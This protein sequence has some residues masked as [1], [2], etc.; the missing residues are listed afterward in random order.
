MLKSIKGNNKDTFF[1]ASETNIESDTLKQSKQTSMLRQAW[2]E[3]KWKCEQSERGWWLERK[4]R[5]REQ[6]RLSAEEEKGYIRRGRLAG[7]LL[8]DQ[9]YYVS[10]PWEPTFLIL[11]I[12]FNCSCLKESLSPCVWSFSSAEV[13]FQLQVKDCLQNTHC[14]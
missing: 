12:Q 11:C 4:K 5:K 8:D 13:N 10:F 1:I 6:E 2:E 3:P 14:M 7:F 9:C